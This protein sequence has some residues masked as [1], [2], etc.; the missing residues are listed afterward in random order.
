MVALSNQLNGKCRAFLSATVLLLLLLL[1][2]WC[3]PSDTDLEFCPECNKGV[4]GSRLL[5]LLV[6][7]VHK[8]ASHTLCAHM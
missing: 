3:W 4:D 6:S 2:C 8:A 7:G 5:Q 1:W